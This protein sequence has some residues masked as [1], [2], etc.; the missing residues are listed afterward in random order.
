MK[1]TSEV[2]SE[3]PKLHSHRYYYVNTLAK[4]L[5]FH[6]ALSFE[7]NRFYLSFKKIESLAYQIFNYK[8]ARKNTNIRPARTIH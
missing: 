6:D 2:L 4:L 7:G 5:G 8:V 3:N 1:K